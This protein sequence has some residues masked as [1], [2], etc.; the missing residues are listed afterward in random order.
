MS[1]P[2]E[3][4]TKPSWE[5]PDGSIDAVKMQRDLR[6]Q[7]AKKLEGLSERE[8]HEWLQEQARKVFPKFK[9]TPR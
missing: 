4:S 6:S 7:V 9:A 3:K 8:Q 2:A 1:E 5:R